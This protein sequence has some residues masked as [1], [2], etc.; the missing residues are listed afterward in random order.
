M[1]APRQIKNASG[2]T[3]IELIVVITIV[4]IIA[5]AGTDMIS[6]PVRGYV[7]LARRIRLVDQAEMAMRRMQ[8][9]IRHALPNSLRIDGTGKYLELLNTTEGGRY[10][11]FADPN[12]GGDDILDFTQPDTSFD[13]LG[14]LTNLPDPATDRLVVYNFSASGN[15]GNAYDSV[16]QNSSAIAGATADSISLPAPGYQFQHMSPYQRFFVVDGPVTYACEGTQLNRYAGYPIA[17][18]QLTPPGGTPAQVTGNVNGCSFRYAPGA[19]QRAGLVTLELSLTE[20]GETITLL[21]QVHVV[22]AP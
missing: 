5:Y 11:R 15:S 7:D 19:S 8:R 6:K 17:S 10:R 18:G 13:V 4:G 22:N 1:F 16:S 9:D 12:P 21:H 2:F 14:S 20:A 3:L